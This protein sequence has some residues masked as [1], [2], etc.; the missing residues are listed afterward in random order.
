MKKQRSNKL[1]LTDIV[2][3]TYKPKKINAAKMAKYALDLNYISLKRAFKI[4][5]N[6]S[7]LPIE[8]CGDYL[9]FATTESRDKSFLYDAKFCG[10]RFCAMCER[11]KSLH[12]G[13]ALGCIMRKLV[14]EEKRFI[15]MTLTVPNVVGEDLKDELTLISQSWDRLSRRA[16]YRKI[17]LGAVRKTEVTYNH[18]KGTYHPHLHILIC[19]SSDYFKPKW[20]R[21]NGKNRRTYPK[22]ITHD[23]LLSDWREA[24]RNPYITQVDIRA[25]PTA[26]PAKLDKAVREVSKYTA[27][28]SDMVTS[29]ETFKH[30]YKGLKGKRLFNPSGIM[31]K[32]FKDFKEDKTKFKDFYTERV[33]IQW[34]FL[35]RFDWNFSK[36]S[37][38]KFS[39]RLTQDQVK[40]INQK[41][42]GAKIDLEEN[43]DF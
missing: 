10:W 7:V 29:K 24:T 23:E 40:K 11:R 9:T 2:D 33:A 5:E 13:F 39:E 21:E 8:C 37:Y 25:L 16:K 12:R 42:L 34:E 15:L 32:Y 6:Q 43:R 31:D 36:K 17:I 20:T 22:M 19:V 35:T 14:H 28:D 26:N 27:K 38:E 41:W 30:F 3:D 4:E 18:E 1:N